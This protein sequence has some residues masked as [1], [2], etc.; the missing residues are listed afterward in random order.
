[1]GGSRRKKM[2]CAGWNDV[3]CQRGRRFE[4]PEAHVNERNGL[5]A[6]QPSIRQRRRPKAKQGED[7]SSTLTMGKKGKRASKAGTAAVKQG[8]GKARREQAAAL[9]SVEARLDALVAKL[10][11]ELED[12]SAFSRLPSSN[13]GPWMD[14]S[15]RR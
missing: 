15:Q 6:R 7:E 3:G 10:G 9:R 5:A 12:K 2:R 1:M 8:P 4:N 14:S 11:E 13:H